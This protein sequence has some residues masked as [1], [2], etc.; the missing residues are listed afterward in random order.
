MDIRPPNVVDNVG[1]Y[2]D[3]YNF[4]DEISHYYCDG[5]SFVFV[6]AHIRCVLEEE[7]IQGT[8]RKEDTEVPRK[9]EEDAIDWNLMFQNCLSEK[10]EGG[11]KFAEVSSKLL[12]L[13]Q[14]FVASALPTG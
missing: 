13:N 11:G 2:I 4:R 1:I 9:N 3:T 14:E 5:P 7:D 6:N 10:F 8:I 12:Q